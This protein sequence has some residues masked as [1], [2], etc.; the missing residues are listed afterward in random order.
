MQ[1]EHVVFVDV[2]G[3]GGDGERVAEQRQAG[4]GMIVL[5]RGKQSGFSGAASAAGRGC[6]PTSGRDSGSP[7]SAT[8]GCGPGRDH[9]SQCWP[10]HDGPGGKSPPGLSCG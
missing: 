7:D 9:G 2:L 5:E 6:C 3:L 4:E 10:I 1:L 8:L